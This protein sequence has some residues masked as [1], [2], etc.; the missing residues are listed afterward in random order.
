[1]VAQARFASHVDP[2][3]GPVDDD[4]FAFSRMP[5]GQ[6]I[7][8]LRKYV[9]RALAGLAVGVAVGFYFSPAILHFLASPAEHELMRLHE[10]R[11]QT[12][13]SRLADGD[14][15]LRLANEPRALTLLVSARELRRTL[16]L[17]DVTDGASWQPLPVQVRPLEW[18]IAGADAER[19]VGR[20][21]SLIS[22]TATE[23]FTVYLKVSVGCG[24]VLSAPWMF[25][26]LWL[27]V[28]AGLYPH[29][30]H[31]VWRLLRLALGLFLGGAALCEF[32]VLPVGLRYL[33][34][35]NEWL[36]F[37]PDLRLSDWV[38]FAVLMPAIFG[39]AFQAPLVMLAL[40]RM[41][42]ARADF[43]RRHRRMAMFVLAVA[44][45][46]LAATPDW[47]GMMSLA[48]PLW[49]LY[50]GG[51]LLCHWAGRDDEQCDIATES[52]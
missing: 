19:I 42:M 13:A 39:L 18:A 30:R 5:L 29:E 8:E 21:P 46:L 37:E 41:G 27:F 31:R 23:P 32:V 12:I 16:G 24:L 26:Q 36:G 35:F 20:P 47:F 43:F 50:E 3:P 10:R 45:A 40:D 28:A 2:E 34:S 48:V 38:S 9:L 7:E 52:D 1:M 25:Y 14:P 11:V 51:I 17:A 49:A 4:F 33:L 6:H 22:L 44:A 15:E